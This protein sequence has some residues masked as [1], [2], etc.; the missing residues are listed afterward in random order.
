MS[1][2]P[3]SYSLTRWNDYEHKNPTLRCDSRF[4]IILLSHPRNSTRRLLNIHHNNIN[5]TKYAAKSIKRH[6]IKCEGKKR[7]TQKRNV[8]VLVSQFPWPMA[9]NKELPW[10]MV[11]A[12]LPVLWVILPSNAG[13]RE[14]LD[15]TALR[16]NMAV[17]T[18][19][20]HGTLESYDWS[21]VWF[22]VGFHRGGTEKV[23]IVP[24]SSFYVCSRGLTFSWWR[25]YGLCLR[26]KPTELAYSFSF[27]SCVCFCL[28]GPFNCISFHELFRHL[29]AFSLCS[30]GLISALLVLSAVYVYE[31]LPQPWCNPLWLTGLKAPTNRL[32]KLDPL[33]V[34]VK[35]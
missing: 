34:E 26:H 7:G 18:S 25:C 10:P 20:T 13:R 3:N 35:M 32:A 21:A 27:C 12:N 4:E 5:S 6:N 22:Y 14:Q 1:S 24:F 9:L 15:T 31:S 28:Y 29:S 2:E 11:L 16:P 19:S 23:M 33:E 8:T 30:S 17:P